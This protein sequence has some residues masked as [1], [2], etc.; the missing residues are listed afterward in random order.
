MQ[1]AMGIIT[2]QQQETEKLNDLNEFCL[3]VK[4]VKKK[5][6]VSKNDYGQIKNKETNFYYVKIP[7]ESIVL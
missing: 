2:N 5:N 7:M 1:A 4:M 6:S 3:N